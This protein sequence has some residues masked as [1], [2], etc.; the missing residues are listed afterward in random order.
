MDEKP[1]E[2]NKKPGGNKKSRRAGKLVPGNVSG[3]LNPQQQRFCEEYVKD[4]NPGPAYTRA[5]YRAKNPLTATAGAWR[6][7]ANTLIQAEIDRLQ[8]KLLQESKV[9]ASRIFKELA[10]IGL[11]NILD[12]IKYENGVY[13]VKP[14]AEWINP[15][16]VA[17]FSTVTFR[18]ETKTSFKLHPKIPALSM[19]ATHS[20]LLSDLNTALSVLRRYGY[21]VEEVDGGLFCRDT[22]AQDSYSSDRIEIERL[23]SDD[24]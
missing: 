2:A 7:L 23:P 18:G 11:S 19:L 13:E 9:E 21:Q 4:L 16:A 12:Y 10:A 6:L 24:N 15:E 22:Y 3:K 1:N 17:E 8:K 5:G 14:S 20:G